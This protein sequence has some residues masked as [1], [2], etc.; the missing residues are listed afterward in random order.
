MRRLL[1][2]FP[3]AIPSELAVIWEQREILQALDTW[4][5]PMP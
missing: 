4:I 5:F 3:L 1:V 2:I